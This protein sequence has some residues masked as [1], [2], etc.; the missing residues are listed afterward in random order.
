MF[1]MQGSMLLSAI[2]TMIYTYIHIYI[3]IVSFFVR[4][5]V[6]KGRLKR[7]VK[8]KNRPV[9]SWNGTGRK[10]TSFH[11]TWYRWSSQSARFLGDG[12]SSHLKNRERF[13]GD[14]LISHEK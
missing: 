11:P 3:H 12:W 6:W 9:K 8:K 1:Y 2:L 7:S 14:K 13:F 4:V 10:I 5:Y